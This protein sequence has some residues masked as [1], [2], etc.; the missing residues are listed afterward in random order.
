LRDEHVA[1]VIAFEERARAIVYPAESG[2]SLARLIEAA[3]PMP[4]DAAF[5]VFDDCLAG[6]EAL[7]RADLVHG[8]V[9]PGV[10]VV[11]ENGT[12]RLRD[13]CVPSPPLRAGWAA[14]TPQYMA[15][16]LWA[17]EAHSP[18]TD[19]YAASCVFFEAL[20]GQPPYPAL[21]LA[22]LRG[23]HERGTVPE[24]TVAAAARSLVVEGTAK[25]AADR[26]PTAARFRADLAVAANAFLDDGWDARG[27]E[28]LATAARRESARAPEHVALSRAAVTEEPAPE[29]AA[30]AVAIPTTRWLRDRRLQAGAAAA[31]VALL[32]VVVT[33]AGLT[34]TAGPAG[35]TATPPAQ[36][37]QASPAPT[38]ALA[39][40]S[41]STGQPQTPAGAVQAGSS[42]AA[43]AAT[44]TPGPVTTAPASPPPSPTP[45]PC[46]PVV[47]ICP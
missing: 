5:V 44:A 30:P 43:A 14:G 8:D 6:L 35:R 22:Y 16:E 36:S 3:G 25:Q 13:A 46:V 37:A 21:D 39:G 19:L 34:R 32:V 1:P 15:P 29:P 7:H 31:V 23:E 40:P 47:P 33:A 38:T 41:G 26:P 12:V 45:S 28:W 27:R 11:D 42:P 17:G 4:P 9:R 2:T 18:S 20:T 24:G 10:V